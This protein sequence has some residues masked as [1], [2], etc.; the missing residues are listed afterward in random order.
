MKKI[1]V[2][3][4]VTL[5]CLNTFTALA[6]DKKALLARVETMTSEQKEAR[7][8]EL[9]LRVDEIKSMDRSSLSRAERSQLRKELKGMNTEAKA[10]EG[11][12]VYLSIG[13]IIIII[14]LLILIL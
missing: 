9:E 3:A 5:L 2:A 10:L 11:R 1:V 12:G 14:L 13:A 8:K 4:F 6:E 7:F